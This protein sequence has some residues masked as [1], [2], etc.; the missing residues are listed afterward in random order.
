MV[1]LGSSVVEQGTHKPL[2]ASSNLARGTIASRI[3]AFD[4][5]RDARL[6]ARKYASMRVSAFAFYRGTCHLFY[7]D[8][9]RRSTLNTAPLAWVSGDLHPENFGSYR[10]RDGLVY[11]D[12]NDFDE[13][14]LGNCLWDVARCLTGIAIQSAAL[15]LLGEDVDSLMRRYLYAYR[16]N[17]SS[18]PSPVDSDVSRGMVHELL[19]NVRRRT[20]EQLVEHRTKGKKGAP[21]IVV[22]EIHAAALAPGGKKRAKRLFRAWNAPRKKRTRYRFIDAAQRIAGTGSMGIERYVVLACRG[23]DLFLFDVKAEPPPSARV[24]LRAAQPKWKCD[25]ERVVDIQ[26]RCQA[27]APTPLSAYREDKRCSYVIKGLE[28]TADRVRWENWHG[29]LDRLERVVATLGQVTAWSH[30]R[31]AGKRG[32][33]SARELARFAAGSVW[34]AEALSR[35]QTYAVQVQADYAAF[36]R[37][38]DTGRFA[39]RR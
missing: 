32:A 30:V 35:A 22:D 21:R 18:D 13:G 2:A 11:F 20:E 37:A 27:V 7:E 8:W 24:A 29:K 33:A 17:L 15:G 39:S 36:C 6:L 34:P 19:E 25:A 4:R 38:Y 1:R 14:V 9:P 16:A 26:E 5:G 31:G 28:P 10:G 23:R 12:V 3:K